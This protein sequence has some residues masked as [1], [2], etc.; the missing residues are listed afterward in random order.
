MAL[1]ACFV[2]IVIEELSAFKYG[3]LKTGTLILQISLAGS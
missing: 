3:F 1:V 2:D